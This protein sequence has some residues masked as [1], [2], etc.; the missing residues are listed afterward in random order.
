MARH[1]LRY[2][3]GRR[4]VGCHDAFEAIERK[5]FER[6]TLLHSGIVDEDVDGPERL[7]GVI[8]SLGDGILGCD[9]EGEGPDARAL[10]GER[11]GGGTKRF[12]IATI[13]DDFGAGAGQPLGQGGNRCR[14]SIR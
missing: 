7:F 10:G 11:G 2:Q 14:G 3:K 6:R 13:D 8:D 12:G 1:C 9:V 4:H 5:L